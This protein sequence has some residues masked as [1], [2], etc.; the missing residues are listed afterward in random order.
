MTMTYTIDSEQYVSLKEED[1]ILF[2]AMVKSGRFVC[3][4]KF[5]LAKWG[6]GKRANNSNNVG[7]IRIVHENA[8]SKFHRLIDFSGFKSKKR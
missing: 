3:G 8:S 2:G 4:A 7:S 6:S 1:R 5:E